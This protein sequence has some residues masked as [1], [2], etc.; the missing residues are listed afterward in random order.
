MAQF[1]LRTA[2]QQSVTITDSNAGLTRTCSYTVL[3]PTAFTGTISL[4][5]PQT[6]RQETVWL[7][8]STYLPP[9]DSG[10]SFESL[11]GPY[12]DNPT[13]GLSK[14]GTVRARGVIGP[15]SCWLGT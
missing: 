7:A 15:D 1:T 8:A 10:L 13:G 9:N 14:L 5:D 11:N 6:T 3:G 12:V 4:A 2:G